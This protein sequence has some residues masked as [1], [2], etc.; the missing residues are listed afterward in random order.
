MFHNLLCV[1]NRCKMESTPTCVV[2]SAKL[3]RW[4]I[5]LKP[6]W[7]F[8][9]FS[10]GKVEQV[11][12]WLSRLHRVSD[13]VDAGDWQLCLLLRFYLPQNSLF[14]LE[15]FILHLLCQFIR[16]MRPQSWRKWLIDVDS[17]CLE[18]FLSEFLLHLV[19]LKSVINCHLLN[20]FLQVC[21]RNL[22]FCCRLSSYRVAQFADR[23]V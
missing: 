17:S 7:S 23:R 22:V 12:D 13:V 8:I 18:H 21:L 3:S 9:V 15:S 5:K 10:M 20:E 16:H 6:V 1:G 2:N 11:T 4:R 19:L 14:I